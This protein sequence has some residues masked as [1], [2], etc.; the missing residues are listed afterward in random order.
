[1][2]CKECND[3]I[4]EENQKIIRNSWGVAKYKSKCSKC[5]NKYI[6]NY[7]KKRNAAIKKAR[8]F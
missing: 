8:W 5:I 1:M 2:K 4:T 7:N 6:N 3:N